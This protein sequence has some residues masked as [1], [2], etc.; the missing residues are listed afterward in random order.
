MKKYILILFVSLIS[1]NIKSQDS[2]KVSVDTV[3]SYQYRLTFNQGYY[4]PTLIDSMSD[5]FRTKVEYNK[6]LNQF[7]FITDKDIEQSEISLNFYQEIT[8]FRKI[9]IK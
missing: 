5:Y 1:F 7:I 8:L 9:P 4:N 3:F 2:L 6:D